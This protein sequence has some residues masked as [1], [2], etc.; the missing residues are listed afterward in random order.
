MSS[1]P[2]SAPLTIPWQVLPKPLFLLAVWMVPSV[3]LS[4]LIRSVSFSPGGHHPLGVSRILI[5]RE[6][7]DFSMS[8]VWETVTSSA[9]WRNRSRHR[10]KVPLGPPLYLRDTWR[11]CQR[12]S[13]VFWGGDLGRKQ[14]GIMGRKDPMLGDRTDVSAML[15][16]GCVILGKFLSLSGQNR[17]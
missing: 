10:V 11:S 12:G 17:K 4:C 9:V 14:I 8:R 2:R 7:W 16:A 5:G 13:S 15:S 3:P 1:G 6:R